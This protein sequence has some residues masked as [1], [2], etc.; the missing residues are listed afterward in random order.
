MPSVVIT[1]R[2]FI[3]NN[4]N[5]E[6]PRFFER[7]TDAEAWVKWRL[8]KHP[9]ESYTIYPLDRGTRHDGKDF[10]P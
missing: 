1:L 5:D 10:T 9:A 6:K 2:W 4:C 7:R 3:L 8:R